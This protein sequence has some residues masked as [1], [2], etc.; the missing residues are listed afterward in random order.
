MDQDQSSQDRYPVFWVRLDEIG[1]RFEAPEFNDERRGGPYLHRSQRWEDFLVTGL[2]F[3]EEQGKHIA[4]RKVF[5]SIEKIGFLEPVI[6]G[7]SR[8]YKYYAVVGTRQITCLRAFKRLGRLDSIK[9][10][11]R[12]PSDTPLVPCYIK[13]PDDSWKD[14][15]RAAVIK[16]RLTMSDL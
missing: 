7:Q 11:S 6:I 16:K 2:G 4:I 8:D 13:H 5:E 10:L 3:E 12:D 14:N 15:T 1:Y 9:G